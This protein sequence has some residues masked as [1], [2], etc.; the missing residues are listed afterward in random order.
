MTSAQSLPE[1]NKNYDLKLPPIDSHKT[2]SKKN[3]SFVKSKGPS[4]SKMSREIGSGLG[5]GKEPQGITSNKKEQPPLSRGESRSKKLRTAAQNFAET[6]I[7]YPGME[8]MINLT[9]K[10]HYKDI[11]EKVPHQAGRMLQPDSPM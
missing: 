7:K 4:I 1:K 6:G 2:A 10:D 3:T 9:H 11:F 8:D 5:L